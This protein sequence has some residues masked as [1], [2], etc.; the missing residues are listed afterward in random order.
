MSCSACGGPQRIT[1]PK[2][3]GLCAV[4]CL[5]MCSGPSLEFPCAGAT[6]ERSPLHLIAELVGT[7]CR[8]QGGCQGAVGSRGGCGGRGLISR[9]PLGCSSPSICTPHATPSGTLTMTWPRPHLQTPCG[10]H[11][12]YHLIQSP[13]L[14]ALP[15]VTVPCRAL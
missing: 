12:T 10:C 6:G 8:A 5:V 1:Q 9:P 13:C 11:H 14:V 4:V 7:V 15:P 2:R 3:P